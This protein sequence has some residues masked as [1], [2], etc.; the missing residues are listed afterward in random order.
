MN[1]SPSMDKKS[2]MAFIRKFQVAEKLIIKERMETLPKLADEKS[3]SMYDDLCKTAEF[4]K[5]T[6]KEMQLFEEENIEILIRRRRI[7]NIVAKKMEER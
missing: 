4:F 6:K 7:I 1:K 2:A 5:P 3:L